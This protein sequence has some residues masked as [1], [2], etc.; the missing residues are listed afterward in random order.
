MIKKLVRSLFGI[1]TAALMAFSLA[2]PAKAAT[3]NYAGYDYTVKFFCGAQGTFSNAGVSVYDATASNAGVN[4][5]LSSDGTVI[6]VSGVPFGSRVVFNLGSV[7]VFDGSKYYVK[8]IRESGMDNNTISST[9]FPVTCDM[10]YVV[11]YG[12]LADSVAYTIE[13]VDNR[14]NTLA[15]T[16]T[17]YGNVGD[18]PVIAFL[19]MDGY[20]PQAYNLTGTLLADPKDNVFRFVYTPLDE[21]PEIYRGYTYNGYIDNGTTGEGGIIVIPGDGGGAGGAGAGGAGAPNGADGDGGAVVVPGDGDNATITEENVPLGPQEIVDIR[22]EEAALS[23][24]NGIF[25]GALD[26]MGIST[27]SPTAF[28]TS[29]PIGAKV[30]IVGGLAA[31]VGAAAYF[32]FIRRGIKSK[33]EK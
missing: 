7:A 14:G 26:N 20:V 30:G 13:Y 2:V 28:F 11:G 9:S 16:E 17:H 4:V 23:D 32:L 3:T 22:D 6:T 33:N 10:D 12:L 27:E 31:A 19:H 29:I 25:G 24:G 18:R 21:L 5:S 15:P 8:G 1:A